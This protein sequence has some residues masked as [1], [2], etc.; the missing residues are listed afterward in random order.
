MTE[1]TSVSQEWSTPMLA[2]IYM[3]RL[4]AIVRTS[5]DPAPV[6]NTRF[7]PIIGALG[8][9]YACDFNGRSQVRCRINGEPHS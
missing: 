2:E 7:V 3:M 5:K 1:T 4:E 6:S 9:T 8:R